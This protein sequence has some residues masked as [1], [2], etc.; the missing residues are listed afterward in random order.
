MPMPTV[1][2]TPTETIINEKI[3]TNETTSLTARL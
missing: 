3:N 2:T 1:A